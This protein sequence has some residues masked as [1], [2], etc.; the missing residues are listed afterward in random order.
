[1]NQSL[2]PDL[3]LKTDDA[4]KVVAE[5]VT[6]RKLDPR[7]TNES[8]AKAAEGVSDMTTDLTFLK[9]NKV[10]SPP[11]TKLHQHVTSSLMTRTVPSH[12]PKYVSSNDSWQGTWT[13]GTWTRTI[14]VTKV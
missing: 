12:L 8:L 5:A 11:D 4:V 3:G 7:S 9:P 6:S 1:M 10:P 2:R 14:Q 13:Q